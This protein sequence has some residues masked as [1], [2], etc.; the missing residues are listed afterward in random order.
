METKKQLL[1]FW[2]KPDKIINKNFF[3]RHCHYA[4]ILIVCFSF[5]S[6][7][8]P[9]FSAT[10]N[11]RILSLQRQ[12][13]ANPNDTTA[14]LNLAMEYTLQNDFVKAVETYF[15][16]LRVD[17]DNFHAY[18]NLGI[19][20]RKSGQFR[21]SLHAYRQAERI[22]PESYWVPYNMGLCFEAM[23]RMQEARESYG[24][25][26]SLNP[27]F[28]QAL[29]RLRALSDTTIAHTIGALPSLDDNQI[30]IVD[31]QTAR[32]SII[33]RATGLPPVAQ[34]TAK[35]DQVASETLAA[36]KEEEHEEGVDP[37]SELIRRLLEY[38][39]YKNAANTF[40]IPR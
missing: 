31:S 7:V 18:N 14:L 34:A 35:D 9:V 25:A 39:K 30:Y 32:P 33:D 2:L 4:I 12:I 20:Y 10:A 17:A 38:Q 28:T 1:N 8:S 16:L 13:I 11:E 5:F 15:S 19:L 37:R 24:R 36:V 27:G 26:L 40:G 22:N 3:F 23:G 6:L 21:D 29:E